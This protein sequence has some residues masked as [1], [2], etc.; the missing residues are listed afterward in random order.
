MTEWLNPIAPFD[1]V[2]DTHGPDLIS[3]RPL[4]RIHPGRLAGSPHV[5]NT[6]IETIALNALYEAGYPEHQIASLYP[7]LTLAHIAESLDLESQLRGNL[8]RAA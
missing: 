2:D 1:T 3:P 7:H 4:I 6:R 5:I 8:L